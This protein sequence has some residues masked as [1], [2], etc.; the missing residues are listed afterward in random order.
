M[1]DATLT[2][3]IREAAD[4]V[5]G[6]MFRT[7]LIEE[8]YAVAQYGWID[9]IIV[10]LDFRGNSRH[11][12]CAL[13]TEESTAR[14]LSATFL[15]DDGDLTRH[16]AWEVMCELCNMF[17]GKF[18]GQF[19]CHQSYVLSQPRSLV[20]GDIGLMHP[21]HR[22]ILHTKHGKLLFLVEIDP[23]RVEGELIGSRSDRNL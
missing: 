5:L 15:C 13:A 3:H 17:C 4:V 23:N 20:P 19:D 21:L 11:G 16:G 22:S 2:A 9:P 18:L 12:T 7:P 14:L 8:Q 1:H 6:T 10:G